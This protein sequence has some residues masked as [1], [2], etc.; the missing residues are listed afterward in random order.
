MVG[1]IGIWPYR[2]TVRTEA[3][4]ALNPCSIPGRVTIADSASKQSSL[5]GEFCVISVT[6]WSVTVTFMKSFL[7]MK[8]KS[9]MLS[10]F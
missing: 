1:Q 5:T 2:L 4:Q 8:S 7:M 6:F 10:T 3:S 9:A